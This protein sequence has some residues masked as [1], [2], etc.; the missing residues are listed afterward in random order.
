MELRAMAL[1]L[2]NQLLSQVGL[3]LLLSVRC[4]FRAQSPH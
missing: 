3:D 2:L 4:M 1:K